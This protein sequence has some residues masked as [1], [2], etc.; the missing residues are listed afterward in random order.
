MERSRRHPTIVSIPRWE[1]I[2]QNGRSEFHSVHFQVGRIQIPGVSFIIQKIWKNYP[3]FFNVC[4]I[5]F[6]FFQNFHFIFC[7]DYWRLNAIRWPRASPFRPLSINSW[8]FIYASK[9]LKKFQKLLW[10]LF[11]QVKKFRNFGS[12]SSVDFYRL[13]ATVL[14]SVL[15]A[16]RVPVSPTFKTNSQFTLLEIWKKIKLVTLTH[17]KCVQ[18]FVR[19]KLG[20][21]RWLLAL[22]SGRT[23][24]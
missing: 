8:R 11:Y 5:R 17:F 7:V 6:N 14:D 3:I 13:N 16:A 12:I 21:R 10:Y 19:L 24:R 23:T 15:A 20:N 22:K 2:F 4:F 1:T 9:N 18:H